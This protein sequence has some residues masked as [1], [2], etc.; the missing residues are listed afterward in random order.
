MSL[1]T[2]LAA[3]GI[4]GVVAGL[5]LPTYGRAYAHARARLAASRDLSQARLELQLLTMDFPEI[6]A[7]LAPA[8]DYLNSH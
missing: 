2:K 5:L 4:L 8:L 7:Q 1:I 6:E 3:V